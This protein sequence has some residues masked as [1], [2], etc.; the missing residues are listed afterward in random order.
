[1]R[2]SVFGW[3]RSGTFRYQL[4]HRTASAIYEAQRYRTTRAIML[5]HSFSTADTS[6]G[7]FQACAEAMGVPVPAVNLVS[8]ERECEGIRPR[9]AWVRDRPTD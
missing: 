3:P 9:L 6:F 5:V 4:L 7:D 2:L 1:M 8:A